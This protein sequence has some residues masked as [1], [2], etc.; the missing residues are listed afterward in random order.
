VLNKSAKLRLRPSV[1]IIPTEDDSVYEFFQSNTRKIKHVKFKSKIYPDTIISLNNKSINDIIND[2]KEELFKNN[3]SDILLALYNWCFIEEV[4]VGKQIEKMPYRRTLNFLADYYPSNKLFDIFST[5]SN[6]TIFILGLGG[7]GSWIA[8]CLSQ[9]GV[10]NFILCDPDIVKIDNLNRSL[11]AFDD[12]GKFKT[13]VLAKRIYNIQENSSIITHEKLIE[14]E[15]DLLDII[16][17]DLE[18]INLFINA[19]DFPNVDFTSRIMS[20]LCL[21][22]NIPHI[23]SGGYN[24]HLS[25]I[26]PTVLPKESAC[27][28]CIE[29]GMEKK[30]PPDFENIKKL[31]REKRNI[32]NISPLAGI[33][34]SFTINEAIKVL[35]KSNRLYPTMVNRRGEFNFLTSKVK[36]TEFPKQPNCP[37]C[38]RL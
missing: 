14:S 24:L 6:S 38:G 2:S 21:K 19:A 20:K 28:K 23:I 1:S 29:I 7:V 16:K 27:F 33:S 25:L 11:F 37:W 35:G 12:I 10:K 34:A 8:T 18:N 22:N 5:I 13:K 26:G 3:I 36:Y 30:Y 9:L 32:G 31:Y 4:E 15:S 17:N